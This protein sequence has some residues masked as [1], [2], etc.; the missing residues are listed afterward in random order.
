MNRNLP[1]FAIAAAALLASGLASAATIDLTGKLRDISYLHPDFEDCICGGPGLVQSALVGGLPVLSAGP[2]ESITDADSFADWFSS[3]N[4]NV[5]G[6]RDHVL[7]L[8]NG[9][10]GNVYSFADDTF[11]PLDGE[12][13]G[14][15]LGY[16]HNY[17]FTFRLNTMFTYTGGEQ[18]TFIGDDDVWVF[19]NNQLVVDLGGVHGAQTGT[20]NLNSVAAGLGMTTGNDY[21]FALFFAERHYSQSNFKIET[22]ILLKPTTTDAPEPATLALLGMGLLGLGAARRKLR[23]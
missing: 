17:H 23:A 20:V 10:S 2:H 1:K 5:L 4:D 16:G 19:I 3:D 13:G 11:F 15:E 21:S 18:F 14:D 9:G 8:D 12:F 7:T 22:S 6:E